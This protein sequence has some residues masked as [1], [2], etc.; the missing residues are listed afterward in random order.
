M[1]FLPLC[2]ISMGAFITLAF[3]NC[4]KPT[5]MD[6]PTNVSNGGAP[7]IEIE[8]K[9]WN[10]EVEEGKRKVPE[11]DKKTAPTMIPV[12]ILRKSKEKRR[13]SK[14]KGPVTTSPAIKSPLSDEE[15]EQV[16]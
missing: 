15:W 3:S 8:E 5:T 6:Q 16:A 11:N 1:I 10:D 7:S 4:I 13:P 12:S 14:K 9:E 2:L